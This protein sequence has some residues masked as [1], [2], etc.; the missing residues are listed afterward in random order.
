MKTINLTQNQIAFID[1]ED[2]DRIIQHKWH[3]LYDKSIN[4]YYAIN[5]HGE[6][7]HRIIMY[8]SKEDKCCIDHKNHNTL[9]NTK[10]NLTITDNRG[11]HHNRLNQ[12]EFG[13][14][15]FFTHKN[16]RNPFQVS[17]HVNGVRKHIGSYP[18]P[19][20]AEIARDRYLKR[21]KRNIKK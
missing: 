1:D 7:M 13:P 16:R 2:Y 6:R 9:D 4:S 12:S 8:L 18:S 15:I 11:N 17:V 20:H 21:L 5:S 10:Q 3:A 19:L 14:C